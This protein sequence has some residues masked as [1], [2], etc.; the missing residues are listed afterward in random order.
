MM[1]D[2]Y[3]RPGSILFQIHIIVMYNL[4][5]KIHKYVSLKPKNRPCWRIVNVD[6]VISN[7]IW[8]KAISLVKILVSGTKGIVYDL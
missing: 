2:Q 1:Q 8:A 5:N 6:M 4:K 3:L 7:E